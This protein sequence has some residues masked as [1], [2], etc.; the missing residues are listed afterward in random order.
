VQSPEEHS[1]ERA[2]TTDDPAFIQQL[3]DLNRCFLQ[4]VRAA[5][6]KASLPAVSRSFGLD[7]TTVCWLRDLNDAQLSEIASIRSSL[8]GSR[9]RNE[10]WT[11]LMQVVQ[12]NSY[13]LSVPPVSELEVEDR[14]LPLDSMRALNSAFLHTVREL[15]R[16]A[17][18]SVVAGRVFDIEVAYVEWL[19][20]LTPIHVQTIAACNSSLVGSRHR[21][22]FWRQAGSLNRDGLQ[23]MSLVRTL[24]SSKPIGH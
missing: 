12:P 11:R 2:E 7:D 13:S 10:W 15:T 23:R 17:D 21:T 19:C 4:T 6:L 3:R 22:D 18:S 8:V 16:Q 5:S 1:G 20:A 9:F 24:V 14:E